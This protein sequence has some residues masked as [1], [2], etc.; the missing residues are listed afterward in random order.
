MTE[1]KWPYPIKLDHN[2]CIAQVWYSEYSEAW[3]WSLTWE[4]GSPY[5]T[6]QHAG[7]ADTEGKAREDILKTMAWVERTWP[8]PEFFEGA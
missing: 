6:H 4:D 5:G 3:H 8:T 7:S 1:Q 2:N